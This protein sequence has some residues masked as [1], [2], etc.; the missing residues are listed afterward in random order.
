MLGV[1][2]T[3]TKG[4]KECIVAC[5]I[6]D[7]QKFVFRKCIIHLVLL[8]SYVFTGGWISEYKTVKSFKGYFS[9]GV[10][11]LDEFIQ[12]GVDRCSKY[13]NCVDR[14]NITQLCSAVF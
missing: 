12:F 1:K 6:A 3:N 10:F 8:V 13:G 4:G 5:N 9:L 11:W 2:A 14:I 7:P